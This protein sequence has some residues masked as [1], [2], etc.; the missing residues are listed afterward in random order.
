[1]TVPDYES[2]MLPLLEFCGDQ[3]DHTLREALDHLSKKFELSEEELNE[4]LPSGRQTYFENRV[5]RAKTY[6]KQAGLIC[7]PRRGIFRIIERGLA[8]LKDKP[9]KIDK[10]YLNQFQE[11]LVFREKDRNSKENTYPEEILQ[12]SLNTQKSLEIGCK[13]VDKKNISQLSNTPDESIEIRY[14]EIR[15]ILISDLLDKLKKISPSK[16]EKLVVE[17]LVKMG[18]GGTQQD[19]GKAVGRSG[20]GGIDGIIN[21]DRLGLDAIYIQAKRWEGTVSRPEIQKFTGALEMHHSKKRIFITTSDFSKDAK[22]YV[23]GIDKKIVLISGEQ[24]A[25]YMID[26]NLGVSSVST[27]TI[28]KVDSDYFADE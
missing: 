20:D 17:L 11:Y 23:K 18:Y 9:S 6:L 24:L 1:M 22:E 28:K 7:Y 27:Y 19:A 3:H 2:C 25:Q 14:Q 8:V 15:Q 4:N 16:F 13:D 10:N 26:Y 5:A 21:E 12:S